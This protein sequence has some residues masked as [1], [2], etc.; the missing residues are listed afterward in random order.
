MREAIPQANRRVG[1][2]SSHDISLPPAQIAHFIA[3]AGA[4]V[5]AIEPAL[6]VNCFGHL[7]DGNLHYNV[8]PPRGRPRSDYD[9]SLRSGAAG[10]A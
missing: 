6:R 3:E 5:A 2:V 7:G 8:F 10:G 1:A 9:N 4:A